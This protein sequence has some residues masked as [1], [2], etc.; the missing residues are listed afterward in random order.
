[1]SRPEPG[2][3]AS[4]GASEISRRRNNVMN[5]SLDFLAI[6]QKIETATLPLSTHCSYKASPSILH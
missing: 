3:S 5:I 6:S 1:M 4:P 2:T